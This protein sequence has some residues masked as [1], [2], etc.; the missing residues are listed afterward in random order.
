MIPCLHVSIDISMDEQDL[1]LR[2]NIPY[3]NFPYENKKGA[4]YG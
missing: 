1:H 3:V 2:W 4:A